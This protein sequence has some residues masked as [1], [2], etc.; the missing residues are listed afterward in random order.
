MNIVFLREG[1]SWRTTSFD[2]T[3]QVKVLS[4][5]KIPHFHGVVKELLNSRRQFE[6]EV[7]KFFMSTVVENEEWSVFNFTTKDQTIRDVDIGDGS[8][9]FVYINFKEQFYFRI[10][11]DP[12]ASLKDKCDARLKLVSL[13]EEESSRKGGK[14]HFFNQMLVFIYSKSGTEQIVKLQRDLNVSQGQSYRSLLCEKFVSGGWQ[15]VSHYFQKMNIATNK[16]D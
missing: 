14:V 1:E 9:V 10:L 12:D 4:T 6:S 7:I 8:Y 3:C 5:S 2:D 16:E 11:I 13:L 15:L